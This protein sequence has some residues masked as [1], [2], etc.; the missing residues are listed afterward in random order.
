M[1]FQAVLNGS[2]GTLST[3]DLDAFSETMQTILTGGGHS[4]DIRI[5][6]GADIEAAL[7]EAAESEG[8]DVIIAAG[9]DG[10]ISAAAAKLMNTDKTLAVLPAGTMNLFARS[11]GM[12]LDLEDALHAFA[13]GQRREVDM[14][15]ANGRPFVHQYSIGMHPHAVDLR[16]KMKFG[17][18]IGKM[19]ASMRAGLTTFLKPP[20]VKVVLTMDGT[21]VIASSSSISV[22][23]NLYGEGHLPYA[24]KPDGGVLGIYLTHA[25]SRRDLFRF[26][27]NMAVGRWR[28]SPQLEVHESG[29]VTLKILSRYKRFKCSIDGELCPLEKQTELRIHPKALRVLVPAQSIAQSQ[30][31]ADGQDARP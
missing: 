14:A 5:V 26:F 18:R 8:H 9:G 31:A 27:L 16:S 21:E 19:F 7:D 4:V 28:A 15:S 24:E 22:S 23:N 1:R 2:G 10:T 25:S 17:S 20:R 6:E 12:P 30:A 11:L 3:M 29:S 13:D